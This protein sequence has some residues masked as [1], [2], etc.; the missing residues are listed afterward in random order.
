MDDVVE[1]HSYKVSHLEE[2]NTWL[3][4][5]VGALAVTVLLAIFWAGAT[6][7]RFSS[8]ELHLSNIDIQMTKLGDVES[9][10]RSFREMRGEDQRRI[11]ELEHRLFTEET[12][13]H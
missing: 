6:Y 3:K 8:M 2:K 4:V 11:S 13:V 9:D 1:E 12:K 10:L 5:L 7:Q